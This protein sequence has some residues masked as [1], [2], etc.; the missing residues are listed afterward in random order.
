VT[1]KSFLLESGEVKAEDDKVYGKLSICP[2]KKCSASLRDNLIKKL[3]KQADVHCPYCNTV[4]K[5]E[6]IK[7]IT[8][9]FKRE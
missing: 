2:N 6:S 1:A 5:E 7:N 9:N 8:F 4:L 3:K